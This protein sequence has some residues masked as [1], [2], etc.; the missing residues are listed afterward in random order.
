MCIFCFRL[1]PLACGLRPALL[2][3][4]MNKQSSKRIVGGKESREGSWPWQ[5]AL[6]FKNKQWCAGALLSPDWVVTAAHCFGK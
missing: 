4:K 1:G 6:L 2:L 5:V 3:A